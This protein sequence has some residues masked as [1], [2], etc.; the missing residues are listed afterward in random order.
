RPVVVRRVVCETKHTRGWCVATMPGPDQACH[1]DLRR[2]DP[3]GQDDPYVRVEESQRRDDRARALQ[4]DRHLV[5]DDA[6]HRPT[7]EVIRTGGPDFTNGL[8][9]D[10]GPFLDGP[11]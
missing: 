8:D 11:G 3:I 6:T 7:D 9:V 5:S 4:P 2:I 1:R 10:G